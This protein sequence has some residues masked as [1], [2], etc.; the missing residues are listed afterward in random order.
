M[1]TE[2]EAVATDEAHA[3]LIRFLGRW[4]ADVAMNEPPAADEPTED[5]GRTE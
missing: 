2:L 5:T 3:D 4:L 1:S